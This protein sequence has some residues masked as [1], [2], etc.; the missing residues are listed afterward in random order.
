MFGINQG[1]YILKGHFT[2][3]RKKN[4]I[5]QVFFPIKSMF[6]TWKWMKLNLL[7]KQMKPKLQAGKWDIKFLL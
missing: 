2:Q 6:N 7:L 4:H 5:Y 3:I 1:I